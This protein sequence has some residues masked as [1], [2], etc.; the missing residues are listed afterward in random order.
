MGAS[1]SWGDGLSIYCS[2]TQPPKLKTV[3]HDLS[4]FCGW[5]GSRQWFFLRVCCAAAGRCQRGLWS[6]RWAAHAGGPPH[7]AG[8]RDPEHLHTGSPCPESNHHRS[9]HSSRAMRKLQVFLR[10]LEPILGS[11]KWS[12]VLHSTVQ[13]GH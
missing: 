12:L 1:P 13:A 10:L 5:L 7:T 8:G 9:L 6:S 3:I 11:P 2:E 4:W